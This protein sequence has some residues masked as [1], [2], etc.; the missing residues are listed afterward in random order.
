[1]EIQRTCSLNTARVGASPDSTPNQTFCV[2]IEARHSRH[3]K[4]HSRQ[5]GP[6]SPG[7]AHLV[8]LRDGLGSGEWHT[9]GQALTAVRT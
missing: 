1:M 6:G 4:A 7:P 8:T 3:A 9:P 2:E 5:R